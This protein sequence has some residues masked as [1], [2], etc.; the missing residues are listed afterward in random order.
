MREIE[1]ILLVDCQNLLGE[2]VL[3]NASDERVYWT[4][5]YA[6]RLYS[7]DELGCD[8][9]I[10]E[11]PEKLGS[12]AFDPD[13]NLL[14]AFASGLFRYRMSTGEIKRLTHFE[15]QLEKTRMN[16]GRCDRAGRFVVGGC[17]Q[18][19][20]NPVSSVIS[21]AGENTEQTLIAGVA[22]SNGIAFSI[23]GSRMY[24][25]DS[26]TRV[27][28]RYDYDNAT[29]TL[30]ER[31]VF[32]QIPA[33]H[34]F[35]DGA[36]VDADD[37]LWNARYYGG[38]V[39]QYRPDGSLGTRVRLPT[40]CPT[41]VCFGGKELDTLFISTGHKDLSPAQRLTQPSAGGLFKVALGARGLLETRFAQRLFELTAA[42][43]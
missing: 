5:V 33:E 13:G 35:A 7:C 17:H 38:I 14:C 6:N 18:E 34:G 43:P 21:Y 4:D 22:L 32:T 26:E 27:Y 42:K 1:A 11:L 9:S 8:L 40:D 31:H 2:C 19:F 36:T 24:F 41:C 3:W 29:G 30:G 15:P 25:S 10:R 16:D 37:N 23:D 20:Y 12:F 28:H 39:Q